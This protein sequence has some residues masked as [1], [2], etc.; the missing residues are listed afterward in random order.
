M[1]PNIEKLS[2]HKIFHQ[3]KR[4]DNNLNYRYIL[5]LNITIPL[6]YGLIS[7]KSKKFQNLQT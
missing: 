4:N 5:G 2:L 3:N 1:L 7:T 6:R